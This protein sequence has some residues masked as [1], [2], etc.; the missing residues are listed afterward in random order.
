MGYDASVVVVDIS[1]TCSGER[2]RCPLAA[3]RDAAIPAASNA[4]GP[5]GRNLVYLWSRVCE[6]V[7][8]TGERD[9]GWRWGDVIIA[10]NKEPYDGMAVRM[11][12]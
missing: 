9:A 3:Y 7:F 11:G 1:S 10:K 4:G 8:A 2:V 12:V 6:C 5:V